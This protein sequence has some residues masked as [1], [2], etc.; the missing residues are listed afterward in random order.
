VVRHACVPGRQDGHRSRARTAR[1]C[2]EAAPQPL[3]IASTRPRVPVP[4]SHRPLSSAVLCPSREARRGDRATVR[5]TLA[6]LVLARGGGPAA[7]PPGHPLCRP[8]ADGFHHAPLWPLPKPGIRVGQIL[9]RGLWGRQDRRPQG[10]HRLVD[11]LHRRPRAHTRGEVLE[12]RPMPRRVS[13]C[14]RGIKKQGECSRSG[15]DGPTRADD[16]R[17]NKGLEASRTDVSPR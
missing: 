5:N 11:G 13:S 16:L 9:G 2:G 14:E 8:Q 17:Y 3:P 7:V 15:D 10:L 4:L 1:A 6:L 12:A